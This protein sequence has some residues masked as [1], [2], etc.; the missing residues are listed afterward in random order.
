MTTWYRTWAAVL[1]ILR[2]TTAVTAPAW[3][4]VAS[5]ALGFFLVLFFDP[6]D[7]GYMFLRNVG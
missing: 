5:R 7:V 2:L 4:Q 6:E 1:R 3:K